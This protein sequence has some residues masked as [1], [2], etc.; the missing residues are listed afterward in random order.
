MRMAYCPAE[1]V[2]DV[3]TA[4]IKVQ[5]D[6]GNR[7]D[8]KVAR[9]KYLLADRGLPWFKSKVEEYCGFS[10]AD[11]HPADVHG[12]DDHMGWHPQGDGRWFYGLNIENGRIVDRD[13]FR[14]KTALREI[15]NRYRPG[16]RITSHQSILFTDLQQSQRGE[17]EKLL[18]DH[19]VKLSEEISAVRR[20]S[21]AC[22][23]WPTC[24]LSITEAERA[25]PGFNDQLEP[26][27]VRLGL[28]DEIFT[29]RVTGCP[30][31]CARPYNSD[32]GLVGRSAGTYTIFLGGRLLGDR[33][34]F[35]FKDYVP[36][37]QVVSTLI[38]VFEYF[39][40]AREPGETLGDFC[41]RKGAEDLLA[42]AGQT[43]AAPTPASH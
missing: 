37:E 13:G 16:L 17:I 41:H 23:A 2:V 12:F 31:G 40:Q 11:P 24:G 39:K 9:L 7:E 6:F 33:L 15:C 35:M 32:I 5:R 29:L 38:P 26:E 19:G 25:L 21:M 18:H 42:H 14:L 22:V 10:L 30:N 3:A 43:D 34:N 20:W 27:L 36:A 1:Q 8:R 28:Q 4:V